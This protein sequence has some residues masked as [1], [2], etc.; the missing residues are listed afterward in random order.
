MRRCKG[1]FV[2]FFGVEPR[3]RKEEMGE[4]FNKETKQGWRV[5]ADVARTTNK[6]ASSEDRKHMSGGVFVAVNSNLG[7][8]IG[9]EGAVT[10]IAGNEGRI[11]KAWVKCEEVRGFLPLT[12]WHS[13]RMDTEK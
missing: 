13:K 8:V 6:N 2:F 9:E 12:F 11:A 10:S 1:A 3:M 4:Q 5:A 7:A